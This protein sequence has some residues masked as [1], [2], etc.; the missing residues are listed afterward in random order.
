MGEENQELR[1]QLQKMKN[2][3]VSKRD[4]NDQRVD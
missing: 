1:Q 2:I 4:A 3:G